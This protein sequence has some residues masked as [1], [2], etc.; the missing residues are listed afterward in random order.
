MQL[1]IQFLGGENSLI[2]HLEFKVRLANALTIE[3]HQAALAARRAQAA[4]HGQ[5]RP[6]MTW[7]D[8]LQAREARGALVRPHQASDCGAGHHP[9]EVRALP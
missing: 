6:L 5:V 8:F 2:V 9:R 7:Q 3:A 4:P 1:L